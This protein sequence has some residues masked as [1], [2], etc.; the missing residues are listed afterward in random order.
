MAKKKLSR[1]MFQGF[2]IIGI[3]SL[4]AQESTKTCSKVESINARVRKEKE[5]SY[6]AEWIKHSF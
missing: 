2:L 4:L 3:L 1:V 5:T 6:S